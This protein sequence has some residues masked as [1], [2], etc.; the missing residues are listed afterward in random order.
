MLKRIFESGPLHL[1]NKLNKYIT[2]LNYP[3]HCCDKNGWMVVIKTKAR[4][5]I[6]APEANMKEPFQDDE[7]LELP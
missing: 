6:N 2:C 3:D 4:R 1:P 7:I 5:I